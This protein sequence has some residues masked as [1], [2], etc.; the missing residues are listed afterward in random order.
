MRCSPPI[1]CLDCV[2]VAAVFRCAVGLSLVVALSSAVRATDMGDVGKPVYAP[3][4]QHL[5]NR[6]HDAIFVRVGPDG[7]AYGH[8]RLDPLLWVQ[9]KHL[10]E[11]ASRDQAM[12]VLNEFLQ[13]KAEKLISDPLKRALLQRDLWMVFHW[14]AGDHAGSQIATD[15]WRASREQL[16]GPLAEVIGHLAL[17]PSQITG[18]IDNYATAVASGEYSKQYAPTQPALPYLPPDL[19]AADGPW[20]CLGRPDGPVAQRHLADFNTFANSAFL[21]FLR[22]PSGRAATHDYLRHL[23]S[24]AGPMIVEVEDARQRT[25]RTEMPNPDLP[26]LPVGTQVAFVRRALLIT[27]KH[28]AVATPLTESIQF[29]VYRE[30]PRMSVQTQDDALVGGTPGNRRAHSW[31]AFYEFRLSRSSLLAG[32]AG[33]LTAVAN[34]ERDFDTGLGSHGHDAFEETYDHGRSFPGSGQ[35]S[36]METCFACHGLPGAYSLNSFLNFRI[37]NLRDRDTP[38][39]AK[40]MEMPLAKAQHTA[41]KWKQSR[42]DWTELR[43]LLGE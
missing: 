28:E 30:V 27:D 6:L 29:R 1:R 13:T 16:R 22:L 19:F 7:K 24:F 12:S 5:W 15:Q 42:P 14:L 23:V 18:L 3:D 25:R 41:V 43:G 31:Q 9:S 33:G 38:R 8:D 36:V 20:V 40:L 21:V 32:R 17:S 4:P 10:L 37:S 34:D 11:G 39:G 2:V 26:Q 35:T